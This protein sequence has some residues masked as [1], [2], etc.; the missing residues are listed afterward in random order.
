MWSYLKV[1][2]NQAKFADFESVDMGLNS[3]LMNGMNV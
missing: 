3:P 2:V 1:V